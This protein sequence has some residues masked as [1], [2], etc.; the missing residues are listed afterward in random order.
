V[1]LVLTRNNVSVDVDVEVMMIAGNSNNVENGEYADDITLIPV[2]RQQ[3][4]NQRPARC[5]CT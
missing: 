2:Q 5:R 4:F 3:R 1:H